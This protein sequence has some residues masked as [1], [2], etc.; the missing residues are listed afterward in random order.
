M[1]VCN[2][3]LPSVKADLCTFNL[4]FG[5]ID[6]VFWTRAE[7]TD[8]ISDANS[9]AAWTARLNNTAALTP[10]GTAAP[11]RWNYVTG[12]WG[13]PEITEVEV[14]N[15]RKA[16][17]I[18]KHTINL[19]IDDTGPENAALLNSL[20]GKTQRMKVWLSI[21]GQ[22]WGGTDPNNGFEMDVSFPARIV[23][24][25]RQEKQTILMRLFLEGTQGVPIADVTGV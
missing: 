8:A 23:P 18:P 5:R 14:S 19:S 11:I 1:A 6:K 3:I 25:S 12:E 15:G 7:A 24:A 13:E 21:D 22:L 4:H 2:I 10:S 20:Q 9:P 17:T 16:L